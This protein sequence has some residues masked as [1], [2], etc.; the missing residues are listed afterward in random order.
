MDGC[1][2]AIV[3]LPRVKG[4]SFHANSAI[5]NYPIRISVLT[6]AFKSGQKHRNYDCHQFWHPPT[7][8]TI[9]AAILHHG[10]KINKINLIIDDA[11]QIKTVF[12]SCCKI[13]SDHFQ[14][15]TNI[16]K[17]K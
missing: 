3:Q 16:I 8:D 12:F 1:E 4:I 15:S 10:F 2:T 7:D 14:H 6:R 5:A 13:F 17:E 9:L 11:K